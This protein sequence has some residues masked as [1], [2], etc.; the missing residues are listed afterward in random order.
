ML[1][2]AG[3]CRLRLV[4]LALPCLL[5]RLGRTPDFP[6]THH[7]Q[8]KRHQSCEQSSPQLP[9]VQTGSSTRV[10]RITS[11]DETVCINVVFLFLVKSGGQECPPRA[12]PGLFG[13]PSCNCLVAPIIMVCSLGNGD[14]FGTGREIFAAGALPRNRQRRASASW[15][16][17]GLPSSAAALP[18]PRWP[19]C[20]RAP[21]LE[22]SASSTATTSSPAI[23]NGNPCS[24]SPTPPNPC[25]RRS[26]LPARSPLSTP[27]LWSNL[28]SPI[29]PRPTSRRCWREPS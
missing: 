11:F 14:L 29:L 9:E 26:R 27:R 12:S 8:G 6:G 28:T 18:V 3:T 10:Q 25:P 1:S 20:W 23:C 24:T 22:P 7:R 17:R 4:R 5:S 19:P 13:R 15:R 2:T 16:R 21:G